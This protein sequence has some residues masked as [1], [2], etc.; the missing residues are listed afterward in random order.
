MLR[1]PPAAASLWWCSRSLLHPW[2]SLFRQQL[3][4]CIMVSWEFG[5]W[6]IAHLEQVWTNLQQPSKH[7]IWLS[8]SGWKCQG[9]LRGKTGMFSMTNCYTSQKADSACF[10][11]V[12]N[13][14]ACF[15]VH[16]THRSSILFS[17]G[18]KKRLTRIWPPDLFAKGNLKNPVYEEACREREMHNSL[19]PHTFGNCKY[20]ESSFV[21][22]NE[23]K[24]CTL[25]INQ[26]VTWNASYSCIQENQNVF[27][28]FR[29]DN[30]FSAP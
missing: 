21:Y 11:K 18:E 28:Q 22:N 19:S 25:T 7:P 9:A 8:L 27:L 1:P 16:N 5:Q 4:G 17:L 12:W 6:E 15:D 29:S 24:H 26:K 23:S 3:Q 20:M 14:D 30:W 13:T 10:G 2:I